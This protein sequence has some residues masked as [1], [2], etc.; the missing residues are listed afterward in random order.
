MR[1]SGVLVAATVVLSGCVP[2]SRDLSDQQTGDTE[3]CKW[4][5]PIYGDFFP[6]PGSPYCKCI[7]GHLAA[8][9]QLVGEPRSECDVF[10]SLPS[11]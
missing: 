1:L 10:N 8:G 4:W 9:Y 11:N 5:R 3:T 7:S 2:F 6:L